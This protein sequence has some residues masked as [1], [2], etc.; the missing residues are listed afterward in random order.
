MNHFGRFI[1]FYDLVNSNLE[2]FL[3]I[4][5]EISCDITIHVMHDSSK[6]AGQHL[7]VLVR[8]QKDSIDRFY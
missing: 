4:I 7:H 5:K 2:E 3:A 1:I 6:K 8:G